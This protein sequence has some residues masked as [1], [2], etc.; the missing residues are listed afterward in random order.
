MAE[1]A[2]F[3]AYGDVRYH[4]AFGVHHA[5]V[6]TREWFSSPLIPGNTLGQY[7]NWSSAPC[8]GEE[9][10]NEFVD[11]WKPFFTST[12]FLDSITIY[13]KATP[14]AQAIPRAVKAYGTAGTNAG[15]GWYKAVERTWVM[16]D[17]EFF[18]AKSVMLDAN[19]GNNFDR[20][21]DISGSAE[22]EA[23][24]G[25]LSALGWA[26]QSRAGFRIATFQSLTTGLN[27]KLRKQYGQ[28]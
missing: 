14:E 10:W 11:K 23:Y 5:L 22:S 2:L 20:V 27:D 26:Y 4:S 15:V 7:Q 12:V 13:T 16:R 3:P 28:A 21:A 9:M 17:T 18:I 1:H 8:D 19:S 25:A 6:P 24:F